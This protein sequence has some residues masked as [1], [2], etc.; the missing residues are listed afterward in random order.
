MSEAVFGN[1]GIP[2]ELCLCRIT[3]TLES[4]RGQLPLMPLAPPTRA[5]LR[6]RCRAK[7]AFMSERRQRMSTYNIPLLVREQ[8]QLPGSQTF[9]QH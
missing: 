2:S 6:D 9:L 3:Y 4:R 5:E 7:I 1:P 8:F